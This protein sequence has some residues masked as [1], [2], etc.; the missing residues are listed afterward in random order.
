MV[1]L[2]LRIPPVALFILV[3]VAM[4]ALSGILPALS[5][6]FPGKSIVGAAL[7]IAGVLVAAAGLFAFRRAQTTFDPTRPERASALVARGVYRF[8]RNPM[9][10][11]ILLVLL[12]WAVQLANVL[13][14][15]G[16]P[17]FVAYLDRF[18]IAPEER[19]L[20]AKFGAAFA[21]YEKSV[22]RWL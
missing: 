11:G 15:L 20:R 5:F 18:Q 1:K 6:A 4:R 9:Y 7:A 17:V 3:A 2:E 16:L 21:A 13:A 8:S 22:R 10:L 19:A 12:G 14:F